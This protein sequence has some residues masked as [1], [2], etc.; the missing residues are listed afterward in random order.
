[1]KKLVLV[2]L[3]CFS[4]YIINGQVETRYFPDGN[5]LDALDFLDQTVIS[6]NAVILPSFD[7][8]M[9]PEE[10]WS[11]EVGD[12]PFRFGYGFD[13]SYSI[14]DG[15]WAAVD[16]GL[17]WSLSFRSK[18]ALSI[19]FVFDQ[20]YLPEGAELYIM[21]DERTT[22]YGPVTTSQNIAVTNN[23]TDIV[24][25]D[26]LDLGGAAPG[27]F[28]TDIIPGEKVSIYIFVKEGVKELP[29]LGIARIVHGFRRLEMVARGYGDSYPSNIDVKCYPEWSVESDG[30]AK[31]LR[32][33]G[34][35][36]CSGALLT[37][38]NNSFKPYFLTGRHAVDFEKDN[39]LTDEEKGWVQYWLFIFNYKMS[40][41]GGSTVTSSVLYSGAT[42]RAAWADTD[43][44]LLELNSSAISNDQR[45][46]WLG[47]D[48]SGSTPTKGTVIHHPMGDV[49]KISLDNDPLTTNP[50]GWY[51]S[52]PGYVWV[53]ECD[54]GVIQGGSS[55]GPLFD[56]NKRVVGMVSGYIPR[57]TPPITVYQGRFDLSWNGGGTSD[58]RLKD[59][60]DPG[61][62]GAMSTTT[63][64]RWYISGAN[65][66]CNTSTQFTVPNL[67][68]GLTVTWS[69]GTGISRLSSQGSNP[70][71]FKSTLNGM[72]SWIGASVFVNGQT[73]SLPT[74]TVWIGGPAAPTIIAS[75]N[76]T[77]IMSNYYY[78][79]P[80]NTYNVFFQMADGVGIVSEDWS[81]TGDNY[82]YDYGQYLDMS[83]YN[84]GVNY[85]VATQYN[86]CSSSPSNR[87]FTV[88][89]GDPYYG[90][91]L[92]MNISPNPTSDYLD[93]KLDISGE[94]EEEDSYR[95]EI[96]DPYSRVVKQVLL[97]GNENR[98]N[99][100]D[101][102]VGYY[103][104]KLKYG[105]E[106]YSKKLIVK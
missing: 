9:V 66:L 104:V 61:N 89:V 32:H 75:S 76:V 1:M 43:F 84:D 78:S 48:R 106:S 90:Y 71:N 54:N 97:N 52:P 69:Q 39:V 31:V 36:T 33:D 79:V 23:V 51:T 56:Q 101:L 41:C 38:T 45:L 35:T 59:W 40:S 65:P 57:T 37:T 72:N 60:L 88:E 49:M 95:V 80:K 92:E 27:R 94:I 50:N 64:R 86:A 34:E 17:L 7:M 87:Y 11:A 30:V 53:S 18:D 14:Q 99:I 20:L 77:T 85:V 91:S 67:P 8:T 102:P 13:R 100:Q 15:K 103:I 58:T 42:F 16:G 70:C 44:A 28:L 2:I 74:K 26:R 93:L 81:Y 83:T 63:L 5:A 12:A 6:S 25:G 46:S 21:N 105:N 3:S 98:I 55:G 29:Y 24:L 62:T 10:D 96:V 22:L 19:N 47:W 68:S 4:F 82:M 73:I